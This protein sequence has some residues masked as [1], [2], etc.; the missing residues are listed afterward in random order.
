MEL[1]DSVIALTSAQVEMLREWADPASSL[2][3]M[4]EACPDV[5]VSLS[6]VRLGLGAETVTEESEYA[7]CVDLEI[8]PAGRS[9]L[10]AIDEL[11][12]LRAR[13]A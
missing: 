3:V 6:L 13:A 8:T 2:T 11:A 10:R 4:D 5:E 9:A 7:V 1:E 12:A